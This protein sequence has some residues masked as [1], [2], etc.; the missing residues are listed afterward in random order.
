MHLHFKNFKILEFIL[1]FSNPK[2][3]FYYRKILYPCKKYKFIKIQTRILHVC[4]I[5]K[6][7]PYNFLK[8]Y[9][10]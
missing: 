1:K 6:I 7:I 8:Y 2:K 9:Q 5:I 4:K 10:I 3:N